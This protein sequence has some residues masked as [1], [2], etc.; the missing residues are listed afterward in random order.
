MKKL[1]IATAA[2]C[3]A[4]SVNA[5]ESANVVGYQDIE[6]PAGSSMRAPTFQA[7]GG[8]GYDLTKI[9]VA[10][11]E[12]SGDVCAQTISAAGEWDGEYYYMTVDGA[13]VPADG[14]Y[15][16]AGGSEAVEE[17]EVILPAGGALFV[18]SAYNDLTL[19]VAGEVPSGDLDLDVPAG[20]SQIG[21]ALPADVDLTEIT[22]TG[23]EGSGDVC[24]QSIS[25]A[26]EWD[27]EYYYMT[28][29]GAGVPADG[30]Y[31]DAGGSEAVEADEVVLAPGEALFIDSAYND[32]V[33]TLPAVL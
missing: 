12:G 7:V 28:V 9:T 25:A 10:G 17:D 15:K 22:V 23:A 18:D 4:V 21:N 27:G 16:D 32:L 30:W 26:G 33:F 2:L 20:S 1:M 11:A 3:A 14:W 8:S 13:G 24:A 5:L 19:K 6:A 29:D 31:K